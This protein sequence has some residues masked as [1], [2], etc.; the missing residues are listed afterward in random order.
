MTKTTPV[1][2]LRYGDSVAI[3]EGSSPASSSV[4]T[5]S[6]LTTLVNSDANKH[7]LYATYEPDSW[8]LD[9]RSR[10]LPDSS[11]KI[12][13]VSDVIS[14]AN[15]DFSS[16]ILLTITLDA[17]YTIE[18]LTRFSFSQVSQDYC[19]ELKVEYRNASD[20]L[21]D[22]QT[23]FPTTYEYRAEL[24]AKPI[25]NV[26][27]IRVYFYSTNKPYRHLRLLDIGIDEILFRGDEIKSA[28]LIEEVSR[29]STEL[30]SNSLEV[31][32]FSDTGEFSVVN[33]TGVFSGLE[34]NQP[35]DMYEEIDGVTNYMG[36]FYLNTWN[37]PTPNT[38]NLNLK[39]GIS[40]LDKS[41]YLGQFFSWNSFG[42]YFQPEKIYSD[43][44]II[45]IIN[46]AG[47]ECEIDAEL[48]NIQMNGILYVGTC[49]EA[50]KQVCF[51][52]GAYATCSRSNK[53]L[54][55]KAILSED[56]ATPD[57]EL[58]AIKKGISQSVKLNP[59]VTSLDLS[60]SVHV[61][62][63]LTY[64]STG[65]Y[66]NERKIFSG[67]IEVGN[68]IIDLY[69]DVIESFFGKGP[70]SEATITAVVNL[71]PYY[72][73]ATY[74]EFECTT[75]GA[76][77]LYGSGM[78]SEKKSNYVVLLGVGEDKNRI[79]IKDG[80]FIS[81][82]NYEDIAN[83]LLSYFQERYIQNVRLYATPIK[84]GDTVLV[85]TYDNKQIQ[86][87]VEKVKTNLSG[88]CISDVEIVGVLL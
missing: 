1:F 50:L 2:V 61:Y 87:V 67:N 15:G 17:T 79:T 45:E 7:L 54:I 77:N 25:A 57:Y 48:E 37:S 11:A 60:Y 6:D 19:T 36:R 76:W 84:P 85:D 13:F 47:L 10:F 53:I 20:V 30:K 63:P 56:I 43:D 3:R 70:P 16:P 21:I 18:Q 4:H 69:P 40:L 38:M 41:N 81:K 72:V 73:G 9:G 22:D 88:G 8:L 23:Y 62:N 39:D 26:K 52:I 24:P 82:E 34:E 27:Y 42:L 83:D 35:A 33:L 74:V 31:S 59:L 64:I 80:N 78:F 44:L 65:V 12:G 86:G 28:S 46:E 71:A 32:L 51:A 29:F 49:R 66:L 55:H 68:Y 5:V 14:D 75:A 58:T